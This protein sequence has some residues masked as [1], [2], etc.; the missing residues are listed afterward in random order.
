MP[1]T[2]LFQNT[3]TIMDHLK[4]HCIHIYSNNMYPLRKKRFLTSQNNISPGRNNPTLSSALNRKLSLKNCF[5]NFGMLE[6]DVMTMMKC[7]Q[8]IMVIGWLEV[9]MLC[10]KCM[11]FSS[12]HSSWPLCQKVPPSRPNHSRGSAKGPSSKPGSHV[13]GCTTCLIMWI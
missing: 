9:K 12:E 10:W 8:N 7:E 2:Q 13:C 1:P 6:K 11:F 4:N 3:E 5:E